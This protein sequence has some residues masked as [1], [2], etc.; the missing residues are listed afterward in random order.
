VTKAMQ[1]NSEAKVKGLRGESRQGQHFKTTNTKQAQTSHYSKKNT[2]RWK[3]K[4]TVVSDGKR[5]KITLLHS[6]RMW[7]LQKRHWNVF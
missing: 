3:V 2:S 7:S 5:F 1:S 6:H 4:V